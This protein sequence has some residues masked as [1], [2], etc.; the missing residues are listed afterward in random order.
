ML[1]LVNVVERMTR[2]PATL[3]DRTPYE[4]IHRN[5]DKLEVRRYR[6]LAEDL[7]RTP[8]LLIPPLM[9]KPF[10]Y[11]L[12]PS[13]SFVAWLLAEGFDVFLVDFGEPDASD[14]G[15]TLESY[16]LDWLPQAVDATCR[17]AGSERVSLIGYCMGGLFALMHTSANRDRRVRNIVN[18]ASPVDSRKMGALAWLGRTTHEQVL[19]ISQRLGNVPGRL[20]GALFK[21]IHP[22]HH[23]TRYAALLRHLGDDEYVET[24]DALSEWTNNFIDY[25][26]E[27]FRQFFRD[28]I[29]HNKLRNGEMVFGEGAVADLGWIRCPL[30]CFAGE[31]DIIAP[32]RST[33]ELLDL[34]A[35][36]DKR[37][38]VVPGGHLGTVAGHA[39]PE[40]VWRPTSRWLAE[41]SS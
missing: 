16:V 14:E 19:Y 35:S 26:G 31:K 2:D 36:D 4:V 17:I 40:Q 11:D 18:I 29:K 10:I 3:V 32:E 20:S 13:R 15:V 1:S 22:L 5:G 8:V 21:L 25:P 34:V 41:R 38:L 33:R 24:F 37:L 12:S 6:P 28:F 23:L 7:H 39:A 30:L 9:V 27:A